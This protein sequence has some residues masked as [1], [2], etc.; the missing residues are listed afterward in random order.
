MRLWSARP[1]LRLAATAGVLVYAWWATGLPPFSAGATVAVVGAGLGA[2]AIGH[3]RRQHEDARPA[4]AGVIGWLVLLV[5]LA[6]WELL[7]FFQHPRSE[8]PTLSSLTN[9]AL[10][11]HTGRALAFATW[12]VAASWLARR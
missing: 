6:G 11:T 4:P 3:V 8:H 9:A 1:A 7:A 2:M 5:A 10:G 12:L